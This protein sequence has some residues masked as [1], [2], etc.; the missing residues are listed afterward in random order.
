MNTKNISTINVNYIILLLPLI[1]LV[2]R[3][4]IDSVALFF[5]VVALLTVFCFWILFVSNSLIIKACAFLI[6][7]S[8][9]SS[10]LNALHISYS[11]YGILI[12]IF[13]DVL[14]I[15]LLIKNLILP[16]ET[17]YIKIASS[18]I[19]VCLILRLVTVILGINL[20]TILN[21]ILSF[22]LFLLVF[23]HF[24]N[25]EKY[26][27]IGNLLIAFLVLSLFSIIRYFY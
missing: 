6:A 2:N 27:N 18:L 8:I 16:K 14:I 13:S 26:K 24:G 10:T 19:V 22:I 21:S 12:G 17:V 15:F 7:I 23:I 3:L 25:Q 20:A 1:Y 5:S 4:F 9:I 11:N